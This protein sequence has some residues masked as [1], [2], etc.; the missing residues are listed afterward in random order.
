[1]FLFFAA[2]FA[3]WRGPVT[4]LHRLEPQEVAG[5]GISRGAILLSLALA[6]LA[7][8]TVWGYAATF[9]PLGEAVY[10]LD[11]LRHLAAGWRIYQQFEF[12]YGAGLLYLPL[13]CSRWLHLGLANGYYF[14]LL[15][16]WLAGTALAAYCVDRLAK[17]SGVS[18]RRA[19]VVLLVLVLTS[20][21]WFLLSG[22]QYV[23]LRYWLAPAVAIFSLE[24]RRTTRGVSGGQ[25]WVLP[26]GFALLLWLYPEQAIA[27]LAGS[28]L[29]WALSLK[30][31]PMSPVGLL[32][33]IVLAVP[34][35]IVSTK[36]GVFDTARAMGSGGYAVPVTPA[37]FLLAGL[38]LVL[39]AG[40]DIAER[41]RLRLTHGPEVYLTCIGVFLMP[42]AM[43]RFDD[44]H[45]L[46]NTFALALVGWM[47]LARGERVWRWGLGGYVF[48]ILLMPLPALARD[49]VWIWRSRGL[50]RAAQRM[51]RVPPPAFTYSLPNPLY[52]PTG[53]NFGSRPG[54]RYTLTLDFGRFFGMENVMTEWQAEQK[55]AEIRS[56]A[57]EPI[58][59]APYGCVMRG[60]R[61]GILI[62]TKGLFAPRPR[63]SSDLIQP[64]CDELDRHWVE[65]QGTALPQGA[66]IR[67][68]RP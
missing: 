61:R 13:A 63:R 45:L 4:S 7:G 32:L 3:W 52:A 11:R 2:G 27:L 10:M 17:S 39:L 26:C 66:H 49:V 47:A 68:H 14:A 24:R 25:V 65:M 12:A 59:V 19:D 18:G 38:L 22:A 33:L 43:G 20:V 46:C 51:P 9:A 41:F 34:L 23:P 15:L 64:V 48:A 40:C 53:P 31:M 57:R 44:V 16:E 56:H 6:A 37:P 58:L 8:T 1:M 54:E 36:A 28:L 55:A 60:D 21:M 30:Q 29:L 5:R 42:A 50:E 67:V 35:L 62:F